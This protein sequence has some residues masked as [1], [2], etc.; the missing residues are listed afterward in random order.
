MG[1]FLLLLTL[2]PPHHQV[3]PAQAGIHVRGPPQT[4]RSRITHRMDSGLRRN[5][6]AQDHLSIL[7]P[8]TI[9]RAYF[10]P[11]L[12]AGGLQ[13]NS[14]GGRRAAFA[15]AQVRVAAAAGERPACAI[16]VY[17]SKTG[18]PRRQSSH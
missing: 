4:S 11:S 8:P 12:H 2:A 7:S 9:P 16:T 14:G 6:I 10:T 3:I 1:V 13:A 18:A 17:C 5:D 15:G